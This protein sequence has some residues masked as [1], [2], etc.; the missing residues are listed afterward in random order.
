MYVWPDRL[1]C[2]HQSEDQWILP[3]RLRCNPCHWD[4]FLLLWTTI[5]N[6]MKLVSPC[7]RGCSWRAL[8]PLEYSLRAENKIKFVHFA[9]LNNQIS[10][11]LMN[12]NAVLF[13]LSSTIFCRHSAAS[14]S[15][16]WSKMLLPFTCGSTDHSLIS[17]T[18]TPYSTNLDPKT[19]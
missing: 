4:K 12:T 16:S 10:L 11:T 18:G 14:V 5:S 2:E 19:S 6:W 9:K 17:G 1:A 13:K 15:S 8:G 3:P 7:S